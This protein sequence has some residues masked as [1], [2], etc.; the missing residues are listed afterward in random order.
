MMTEPETGIVHFTELAVFGR[1]DVGPTNNF[2][3]NRNMS[4]TPG[5]RIARRKF[6]KL[7]SV[8]LM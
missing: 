8:V 6:G 7:L 3:K 4:E 2:S 1:L 5:Y